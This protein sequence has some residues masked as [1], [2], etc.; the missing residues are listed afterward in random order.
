MAHPKVADGGTSSRYA[1]QLQI[2]WTSRWRQPT[3]S[4]PPAWELDMVL[5]TPHL[6]NLTMLRTSF[7]IIKLDAL[8]SQIYFGMKFYMFRAVSLPIIRSLITVHSAL[9]YVIQVWRQLSSRTRME[10]RRECRDKSGHKFLHPILEPG[11]S[12][13]QNDIHYNSIFCSRHYCKYR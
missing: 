4:D 2:Y 9:V 13:I 11:T 5:T 10:L 7:F 6:T 8:I 1:G 12:E 3:R